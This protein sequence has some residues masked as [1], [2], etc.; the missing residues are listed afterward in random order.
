MAYIYFPIVEL[1]L[2]NRDRYA[3]QPSLNLKPIQLELPTSARAGT[4]FELM[5][6]S[7][8]LPFAIEPRSEINEHSLTIEAQDGRRMTL[9]DSEAD[10]DKEAADTGYLFELEAVTETMDDFTFSLNT[11]KV[12]RKALLLAFKSYIMSLCGKEVIYK[13]ETRFVRGFQY[14]SVDS[15]SRCVSLSIYDEHNRNLNLSLL[16]DFDSSFTQDEIN[17]IIASVRRL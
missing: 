9:I 8:N 11:K 4:T 15:E 1:W 16:S 17:L 10:Q 14:G 7:M 3:D 2:K 6:W 5:G 12:P 13:F